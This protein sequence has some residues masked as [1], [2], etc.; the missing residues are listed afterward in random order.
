MALNIEDRDGFAQ[1]WNADTPCLLMAQIYSCTKG[2]IYHWAVKHDLRPRDPKGR[3]IQ[4]EKDDFAKLWTGAQ[5]TKDIAKGMACTERTVVRLAEYFQ[6]GP[7]NI[8]KNV[9][10]AKAKAAPR[11]VP[12]APFWTD[13]RDDLVRATGGRYRAVADLAA[14]LAIDSPKIIARWHRLKVQA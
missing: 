8:R 6:L 4:I 3:V 10:D 5:S 14:D 9:A 12:G 7:R 13:A 1:L 2:R 11:P